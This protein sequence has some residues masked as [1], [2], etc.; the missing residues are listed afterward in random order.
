MQVRP[1]RVAD[2]D[3]ILC[4]ERSWPESERATRKQF[5]TRLRR[6]PAGFLV[7]EEEGALVG[8]MTAGPVEYSAGDLG[9]F[10]SWDE[11][12]GGGLLRE[13]GRR[14]EDNALYIVSGVVREGGRGRGVI[15]GL[16]LG[17]VEVARRERLEYLVAGATLPRYRRYC[18]RHGPIAAA[19]YVFEERRGR[20]V[21]PFLE[22]YR[23]IGFRVPD[24]RHVV[25]DYYPDPA[26][27]GYAALV[28]RRVR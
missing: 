19:D 2:L 21:E 1:A 26:S 28:V 20:L 8:T 17:Q 25:R 3:E 24:S 27:E 14:P 23:Q 9:G 4:V 5:E 10:K 15:Q 18:E 16:I 7:A 13:G 12:T 11:A 22:I 6:Y